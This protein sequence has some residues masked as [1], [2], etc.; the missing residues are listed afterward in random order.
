[1]SAFSRSER[2]PLSLP[3]RPPVRGVHDRPMDRLRVILP[4]ALSVSCSS[5]SVHFTVRTRAVAHRC[6]RGRRGHIR[7]RSSARRP[8][9]SPRP[10]S[11]SA[12]GPIFTYE[13]PARPA[14]RP[15]AAPG[16]RSLKGKS[17]GEIGASA[18]RL[19]PYGT[20]SVRPA[21]SPRIDQR[22]GEGGRSG[23]SPTR[24]PPAR[25]TDPK[26]LRRG[27]GSFRRKR[28]G[29][30]RDRGGF[31]HAPDDA[32]LTFARPPGCPTPTRSGEDGGQVGEGGLAAEATPTRPIFSY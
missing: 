18:H 14:D 31:G 15:Q 17:A 12:G 21:I 30:G 23:L 25:L 4:S 16:R 22:G 3:G 29:G 24:L 13:T 26:P 1:M 20:L 32:C 27:R 5:N 2:G 9:P 6:W 10:E 19:S 28:V 7:K 11:T 8:F